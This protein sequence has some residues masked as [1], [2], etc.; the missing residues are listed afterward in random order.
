M[1]F[2]QRLHIALAPAK[3][4]LQSARLEK[5]L[6]RRFFLGLLISG[7]RAEPRGD[8]S[9]QRVSPSF[10]V[11]LFFIADFF[12]VTAVKQFTLEISALHKRS[13]WGNLPPLTRSQLSRNMFDRRPAC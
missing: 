4:F 2:I 11:C 1:A 12:I 10:F 5:T 13:L 9:S 7:R 6:P 3:F 8:H